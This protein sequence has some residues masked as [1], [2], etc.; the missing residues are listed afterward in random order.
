MRARGRMVEERGGGKWN[1]HV[2]TIDTLEHSHLALYD[3]LSSLDILLRHG[4]Q[5]DLA[6]DVS[7][8]HLSGG[9]AH[10]AEGQ[11]S[12]GVRVGG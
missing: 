6:C 7:W 2:R 10:G 11:R 8:R 1:V 12:G 3:L 9:M 5:Y 4:L